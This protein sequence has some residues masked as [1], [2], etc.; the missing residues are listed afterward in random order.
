[1]PPLSPDPDVGT[2]RERNGWFLVVADQRQQLATAE[3][4]LGVKS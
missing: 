1:M 3:K 2:P 4:A